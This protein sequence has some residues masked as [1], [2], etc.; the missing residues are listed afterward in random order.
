[1]VRSLLSVRICEEGS[2]FRNWPGGLMVK[3]SVIGEDR[4]RATAN[5]TFARRL[6]LRYAVTQAGEGGA[7]RTVQSGETLVPVPG[8]MRL[9]AGRSALCCSLRPAPNERSLPSKGSDAT[10]GH[11]VSV[12]CAGPVCGRVDNHVF[13][14]S[15][16]GRC[17]EKGER[18]AWNQPRQDLG[19][20]GGHPESVSCSARSVGSQPA[21]ETSGV[22]SAHLRLP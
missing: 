7:L 4:F 9:G 12:T 15:K 20:P 17:Q 14:K 5:I 21:A 6:D 16:N 8:A 11:I 19:L 2:Q 10:A 18:T 3:S 1:M 22:L 13:S